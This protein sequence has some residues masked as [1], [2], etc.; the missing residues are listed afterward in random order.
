MAAATE[1]RIH[2]DLRGSG[3]GFFFRVPFRLPSCLRG[4][5]TSLNITPKTSVSRADRENPAYPRF[6]RFVSAAMQ[7]R[8]LTGAEVAERLGV[9]PATVTAWRQGQ[10]RPE[11]DARMQALA[12]LLGLSAE[13]LLAADNPLPPPAPF[14]QI[15]PLVQDAV[16]RHLSRVIAMTED[17]AVEITT[18]L[19]SGAVTTPASERGAVV[20]ASRALG[21]AEDA[22]AT[23]DVPHR[24]P[25]Q[26]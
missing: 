20:G 3:M 23:G 21:Q 15:N 14:D 2:S 26:A 12:E 9:R 16:Q 13:V 5:D 1:G 18:L 7:A 4:A 17:L 22:G 25:K 11:G 19:S 10:Y 8:K 24:L 6:G